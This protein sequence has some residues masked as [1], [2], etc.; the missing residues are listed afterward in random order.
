MSK[1]PEGSESRRSGRA[2]DTSKFRWCDGAV[3]VAIDPLGSGADALELG[4]ALAVQY[5][6]RLALLG[7]VREPSRWVTCSGI[8]T[9]WTW[10]TL[11]QH[12]LGESGRTWSRMIDQV[13]ADISVT[14]ALV[15]GRAAQ[16][17]NRV[18][19]GADPSKIVVAE[20][21]HKRR[22]V[23]RWR[24]ADVELYLV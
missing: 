3:I 20:T 22:H 1:S 15:P 21:E 17:I 13:P 19:A 18:L 12:T 24:Q 11:Q 23:R 14:S 5:S 16:I 2:T 4:I 7:L 10:A 9:P 8:A 6:L